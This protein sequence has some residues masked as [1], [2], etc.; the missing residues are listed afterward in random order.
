MISSVNT[1]PGSGIRI[2]NVRSGSLR[3][4]N[5]MG[6]GASSPY[7]SVSVRKGFCSL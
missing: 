3:L 2:E 1:I 4:S 6:P 7:A 5:V